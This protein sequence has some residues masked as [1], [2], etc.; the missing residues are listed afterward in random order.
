MTDAPV[1]PQDGPRELLSATR[2]LTR[3]VRQTQRGTWFPLLLFAVLTLASIPII[4]YNRHPIDCRAL[5]PDL[6]VCIAFAPASYVYWPLALVLA[7]AAIAA[8]YVHRA[9]RRGVGTRVRPYVITGVIIAVVATGIS[10]W[11]VTHAGVIGYPS[12]APPGFLL[13]RLVSPQG[14][15]GLALLVLARVERNRALLVFG[16]VYLVIVGFG[17]ILIPRSPWLFLASTA[18]VL[19]LGSLG[20]ALAERRAQRPAS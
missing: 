1:S 2:R 13:F 9:R 17:W 16:L 10:L 7:Y 15:I 12:F 19:L 18:A 14:A 4:R 5:H 11:L 6:R 8:F 20:F 3:Q